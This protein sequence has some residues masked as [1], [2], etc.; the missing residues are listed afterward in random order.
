ML[1]STWQKRLVDMNITTL[2]TNDIQWSD[3]VFISAMYIQKE[4]VNKIIVDCKKFNKKIVAGG[5]L[6]TQEYS[7]YP[8]VDYFVLKTHWMTS[9]FQYLVRVPV[10]QYLI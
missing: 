5:P 3:Y 9:F 10:I 7:N 2:R 6:F 8:Q 4:S 1:P